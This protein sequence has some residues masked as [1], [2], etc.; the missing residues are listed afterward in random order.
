MPEANTHY[1]R[2]IRPQ[3]SADLSLYP[4]VAVMGARQVGKSTICQEIA[5]ARGFARRT[6]DERDVREQAIADPE[7]LL[8]DLGDRPDAR[9]QGGRRPG[10]AQRKVP[11]QRV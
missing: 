6:L 7:G 9:H 11:A 2:V 10:R 1:P 5:E 8:A 3:L 4:V